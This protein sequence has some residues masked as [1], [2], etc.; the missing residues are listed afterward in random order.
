MSEWDHD[1]L[2][3]ISTMDLGRAQKEAIGL[4]EASTTRLSKKAGLCRDFRKARNSPEVSRILYNALLSGE[5]FGIKNSAWQK[6][7]GSAS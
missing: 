7:H 5:G 3:S 1:L 4:V 2:R 6:T